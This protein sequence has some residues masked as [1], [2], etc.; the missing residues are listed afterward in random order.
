MHA[1]GLAL[2]CAGLLA[3]AATAFFPSPGSVDERPTLDELRA[4]L[5]ML[6][7][8]ARARMSELAERLDRVKAKGAQVR[9]GEEPRRPPPEPR[10]AASS[11]AADTAL[12]PPHG[13]VESRSS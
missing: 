6:V 4:E 13:L 7:S 2:S 3:M 9:A 5:G 10:P 11:R 1:A 12:L 8:E